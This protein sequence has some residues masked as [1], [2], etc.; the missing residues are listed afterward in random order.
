ML[1]LSAHCHDLLCV[2]DRVE[3]LGL[4]IKVHLHTADPSVV[5]PRVE[6][7][8]VELLKPVQ[9]LH[10]H[11]HGPIVL[12]KSATAARLPAVVSYVRWQSCQT[13]PLPLSIL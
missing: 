11:G 8:Q 13:V 7:L 4:L 12:V 2:V 10:Y 3:H 5:P 6:T 1:S 9:V